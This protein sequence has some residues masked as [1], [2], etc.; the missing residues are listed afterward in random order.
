VR[1]RAATSLRPALERLDARTLPSGAVTAALVAGTL[2]VRGDERDD[3]VVIRL[4]QGRGIAREVGERAAIEVSGAGRFP[5]GAVRS[6]DV[7][8]GAG[9]DVVSL[10]FTRRKLAVVLDGGAGDDRIRGSAGVE[11]I[12][13]GAGDDTIVGRGGRDTVDPGP[14]S[15]RVN[16]RIIIITDPA[17]GGGPVVGPDEPA[18]A[19]TTKPPFTILPPAPPALPDISGWV[20]RLTELVNAERAKRGL[21]TLA[22]NT[23]LEQIA[24]I[25][26]EQMVRFGLMQHT[27]PG[28]QYPDMRSRADAVGY[29]LEWLGENLA[30]NYPDPEGVV[31]GWIFSQGHRENL[32]FATATEMGVAVRLD[33]WGRVYVALELGRPAGA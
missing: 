12:R 22:Y 3:R 33:E 28:A 6:I 24:R 9:N 10:R 30:Y 17:P 27:L 29:R 16:G 2:E 32:L 21:G 23:Q 11:Q 7:A 25:Q 13:G 31:Q 26:A 15:N 20:T 19:P 5:L 18:P 14:G 4:V 8:M 1:R